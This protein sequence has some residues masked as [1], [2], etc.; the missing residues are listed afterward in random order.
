ME[1]ILYVGMDVHKDTNSVCAYDAKNDKYLYEHKMKAN[2]KNVVKYLNSVK[3]KM[4][5]V[6]FVCGYEADP[7]GFGLYRDLQKAG[8]VCVVMVPTSLKRACGLR[9]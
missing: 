7:T 6:I 1:S 5:D 9:T 4:G 2:S 8:I 3:E